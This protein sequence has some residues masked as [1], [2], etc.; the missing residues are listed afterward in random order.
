MKNIYLNK[1]LNADFYNIGE[2]R[3]KLMDTWNILNNDIHSLIIPKYF[4]IKIK[5]ELR[6]LKTEGQKLNKDYLAWDKIATEFMLNPKFAFEKNQEGKN[7]AYTHFSNSVSFLVNNMHSNI[8]LITNNY[9]N[10]YSA[11]REQIN[12]NRA[13]RAFVIGIIGLSIALYT[14]FFSPKVDTEIINKTIPTQM[15]NFDNN[16]FLNSKKI[17]SLISYDKN[18][19]QELKTIQRLHKVSTDS[20]DIK[21]LI[22]DDINSANEVIN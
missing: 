20:S 5:S 18:V 10:R 13:S 15:E 17:D 6:R 21:I 2:E 4:P 12:F 9:N 22:E 1:D 16:L 8:V 14:T 7:L 11:Y 3:N 19:I